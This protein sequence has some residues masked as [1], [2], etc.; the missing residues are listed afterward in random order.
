[1]KCHKCGKPAK[2]YDAE[3]G[4]AI[5]PACD[6]K[7]KGKECNKCGDCCRGFHIPMK[8]YPEDVRK[9][10]S[11]HENCEIVNYEG[12]EFL[13]IKNKCKFLT[14]DNLC[15]IYPDRPDICK[16]AYT[17]DRENVVFP[18]KCSLK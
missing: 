18:A 3:K 2:I 1:M 8:K 13:Y 4:R 7:Q 5:C 6:T 10:L 11:Y 9:Y 14:K 17:E 15:E 12:K 16:R